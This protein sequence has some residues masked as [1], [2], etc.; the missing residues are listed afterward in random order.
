MLASFSQLASAA[1]LWLRIVDEQ[2][3]DDRQQRGR[4]A[5]PRIDQASQDPIQIIGIPVARCDR[6]GF[7]HIDH[8]AGDTKQAE[9]MP[10]R[11]GTTYRLSECRV[12]RAFPVALLRRPLVAPHLFGPARSPSVSHIADATHGQ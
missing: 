11:Q 12:G 8:Q 6:F 10:T 2:L 7:G 4:L 5:I 3:G 1:E 9:W